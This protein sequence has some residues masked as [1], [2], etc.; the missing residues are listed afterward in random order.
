MFKVIDFFCG[1][2]GT[3][4][5]LQ[6]AGMKIVAGIY[7]DPKAIATYRKNFPD[8]VI[9]NQD[10]SSVDEKDIDKLITKNKKDF[11]VFSACAPCQPFSQQNRFKSNKD[12]RKNLLSELHRFIEKIAPDFIL[13]ENVPGMQKIQDGPFPAFLNF[14]KNLNYKYNYAVL[15]AVNFGVPQN[16]KRLVLLAAK[17]TDISLPTPQFGPGLKKYKVV[18]D[19]IEKFPRINAGENDIS[20][21][22]HQAASLSP[23]LLER[24]KALKPGESRI[25]WPKKLQLQCHKK[26]NGHTDVYGRLDWDKPS[27]TLTTKCISLSNGRFGHPEQNRALS[28]REAAAIQTFPDDF[29]FEGSPWEKARQIGNAV[30]VQFAKVLGIQII[31]SASNDKKYH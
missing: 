31:Q 28:V 8:S 20:I 26:C 13:I 11:V 22:D 9:I 21:P 27:V 17:K 10:I 2:G 18:R 5:G 29:L 25:N 1:C 24:I 7:V 12:S 15:N 23:L 30:P 4:A 19:A 14:I 3:S 6:A 16:R